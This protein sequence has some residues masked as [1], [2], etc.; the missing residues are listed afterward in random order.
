MC[1]RDRAYEP[2]ILTRQIN[3]ACR[4]FNKFYHNISILKA[5]NQEIREARLALCSRFSEVLSLALGL[6]GLKTVER[7]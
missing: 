6:L 3:L 7:M 1:I 5:E 2:C 4:D